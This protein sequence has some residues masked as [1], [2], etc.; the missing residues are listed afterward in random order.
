MEASKAQITKKVTE[1][2]TKQDIWAAYNELIGQIEDKPIQPG[3]AKVREELLGKLEEQRKEIVRAVELIGGKAAESLTDLVSVRD[4]VAVEKKQMLASYAEQKQK[5]EDEIKTIRHFWEHEQQEK[6]VKDN[7]EARQKELARRKEEDEYR[8][9]TER[10][11][12]EELD[13][14]DREIAQKRLDIDK[15]KAEVAARKS[16]IVEMGKKIDAFPVQIDK[17]VKEAQAQLS[18]ELSKSHNHQIKETELLF[19]GKENLLNSEISNLKSLS[20]SRAQE[21]ESQ[22]K[23]LSDANNRLKEM[24]VS[25]IGAVRSEARKQDTER[26]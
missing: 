11:R 26:E 14:L 13:K 10:G 3:R 2:N 20:D 22:K 9:M 5:I 4:E 18:S 6:N 24:A 17:A 12:R 16:E 8:F 21:I 19:Q 23:Q 15:E 1:K 7:E 25:A